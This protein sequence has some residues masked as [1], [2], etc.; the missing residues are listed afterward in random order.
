MGSP[1]ASLK[2]HA[3][4]RDSDAGDITLVPVN[5]GESRLNFSYLSARVVIRSVH[6]GRMP[7]MIAVRKAEQSESG[8]NGRA[9]DRGRAG[10]SP[11]RR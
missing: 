8:F 11:S 6:K 9:T 2:S 3:P 7:T 10:A 5:P 4:A 1:S